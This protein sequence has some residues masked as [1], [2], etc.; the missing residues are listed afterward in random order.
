MLAN[1]MRSGMAVELSFGRHGNLR[2]NKK[3]IYR[4]VEVVVNGQ[5]P[6]TDIGDC[7][8]DEIVRVQDFDGEWHKV[9]INAT[10]KKKLVMIR[11]QGW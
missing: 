2:C 3:G 4:M 5:E 1:D 10:H 8:I 6:M 11:N 9:E 7:Y